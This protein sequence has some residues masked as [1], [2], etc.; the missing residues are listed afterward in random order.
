M[1]EVYSLIIEA[2]KGSNEAKDTLVQKNM[3]LIWSVVKRF[4]NRGYEPDDLFQIGAIGLIK[5][6]NKFDIK[7]DV[8]FSTYAVPMIIGE[9]KRF[10]RDDGVVKVS[11]SVKDLA[12][13]A[14]YETE[15]ISKKEGR[16]PSISELSEILNVDI[17]DLIVAL[18]AGREVE[19][20]YSTI[21]QGD[22][23]NIYLIDK[24]VSNEN[25]EETIVDHLALKQVINNLE[26]KEKKIIEL[27]YFNDKTQSEVA[28]T[29]GISQ[30]QV[31]RI[32][33]KVLLKI[34]NNLVEYI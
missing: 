3:G 26:E 10:L 33:K 7:Y 14:K 1:D 29:V 34:R 24:M 11:R 27:R 21:H 19:S 12:I 5:C 31:S 30:V 18:E 9:I 32:E 23:S 6:I 28:K 25:N 15:K 2:Q 22:G 4:T 13:K 16:T 8:K 20:L 17:D